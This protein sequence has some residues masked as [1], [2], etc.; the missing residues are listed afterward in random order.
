MFQYSV[1]G[2]VMPDAITYGQDCTRTELNL[3]LHECCYVVE[4]RPIE[5]NFEVA[6]EVFWSYDDIWWSC[7]SNFLHSIL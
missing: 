4:V 7:N 6:W 3:P 1:G 5:R 2:A